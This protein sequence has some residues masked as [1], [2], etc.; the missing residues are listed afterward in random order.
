MFAA[1]LMPI[2]KLMPAADLMAVADLVVAAGV[3]ER[4]ALGRMGGN[5]S[6]EIVEAKAFVAIELFFVH[7]LA[8]NADMQ[9]SPLCT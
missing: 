2:A 1:K 6:R 3:D 8:G 4:N 7:G 5:P 9:A